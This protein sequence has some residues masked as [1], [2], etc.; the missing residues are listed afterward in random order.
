LC[1][2]WPCR[3]VPAAASVPTPLIWPLAFFWGAVAFGVY[4]MALV[5]LG[6]RFSGSMLITGNSA[7]A[8]FWGLGGIVGPPVTGSAMTQLGPQ[9]LP[10]T[11]GLICTVLCTALII[12][13]SRRPS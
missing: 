12:A 10:L 13:R 3:R 7:F 8:L 5:M 11:L 1:A 2:L 9:G 4:T 6:E